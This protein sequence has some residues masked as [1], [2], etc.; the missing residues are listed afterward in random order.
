MYWPNLQSVALPVPEIIATEFFGAANPNL[1]ERRLYGVC[2]GTVPKS[3]R[4][5]L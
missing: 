1:G 3:V 5:F 2:G 4:D